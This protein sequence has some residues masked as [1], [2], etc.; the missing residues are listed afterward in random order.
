[1]K[2]VLPDASRPSSSQSA[3]RQSALTTEGK[4]IPGLSDILVGRPA[5]PSRWPSTHTDA[6]ESETGGVQV[7]SMPQ[8]PSVLAEVR[9]LRSFSSASPRT[10][11]EATSGEPGDED[12]TTITAQPELTR[13]QTWPH[14]DPEI[15]SAKPEEQKEGGGGGHS[16]P[17][18][19][20]SSS[21]AQPQ[22]QAGWGGK[23]GFEDNQEVEGEEEDNNNNNKTTIE[24]QYPAEE[25]ESVHSEEADAVFTT[26][27]EEPITAFTE[28]AEEAIFQSDDRDNHQPIESNAVTTHH[29]SPK[30]LTPFEPLPSI[31]PLFS[32]HTSTTEFAQKLSYIPPPLPEVG[33]EN[34]QQPH[35]AITIPPSPQ[36]QIQPVA[37]QTSPQESK[38]PIPVKQIPTPAHTPD[39][40]Q[41]LIST[42]SSPSSSSSENLNISIEADPDFQVS[43]RKVSNESHPRR[44]SIEV[45]VSRSDTFRRESIRA[46]PS[47]DSLLSIGSFVVE[48]SSRAPSPV[49]S[50]TRER[51]SVLFR[52][53]EVV[54]ICK[55]QQEEEEKEKEESKSKEEAVGSAYQSLFGGSSGETTTTTTVGGGRDRAISDPFTTKDTPTI[56]AR[57][58]AEYKIS[59]K[60]FEK[61]YAPEKQEEEKEQPILETPTK[62][63]PAKKKLPTIPEVRKVSTEVHPPTPTRVASSVRERKF[64]ST[65]DLIARLAGQST[66]AQELRRSR[67]FGLQRIKVPSE[68]PMDI[69]KRGERRRTISPSLRRV[70][71]QIDS[72]RTSAEHV[73]FNGEQ[74]YGTPDGSGKGKARDVTSTIEY[75]EAWGDKDGEPKSP[76]RPPSI[77]RRQS[78][79]IVDLENRLQ[80]LAAE[81]TT[82]THDKAN[83]EKSLVEAVTRGK[84]EAKALKVNLEEK[85]A[86]LEEKDSQIEELQRKISWYRTEVERL[87]QTNDAL[88]QTNDTLS[89]T[90]S[91]LSTSYK[92]SYAALTAKCDKKREAML[93]LSSE[94]S[95]LQ[96]N[97]TE[98]QSGM[99]SIIRTELSEKDAELERLRV[100]LDRAREE[101]RKLQGKVSARQTNQYIDS[102]DMAYF[103]SSCKNIFQS[104]RIF[105]KQFSS[106]STGKKCI[107][108]H[109]ITDETIRDRVEAVMLDDRGV[110]RMLKEEKRRPEVFMAIIMRM[111]WELVFTRYLF[112]LEAEERR[113]LLSLEKILTDVGAPAAV[114]QWRATT[115]TLLSQRP[116]FTPKRNAD[117]E[118][119]VSTILHQ[120]STLLPPPSQYT[121]LAHSSLT[122]IITSAVALA[123]EMRTQRAEYV[124]LRPPAPTYDENGDVNNTVPFVAARM[125]NRGTDPVT[126]EELEAEGATVKAVL[127]PTL[128]R[129]GNEFGEGYE[130]ESVVLKMQ[131]L[132]NRPLLRS[133]SRAGVRTSREL[134]GGAGGGGGGGVNRL[135]PITDASPRTTPEKTRVGGV[136]E[137]VGTTMPRISERNARVE[138]MQRRRASARR[139][140]SGSGRE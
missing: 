8:T 46:Q 50:E 4:K 123:V 27:E 48:D 86:L 28:E 120:L 126:D 110:R 90:N 116:A 63:F 128:I 87:S 127:F 3:R 53:E 69:L 30:L 20:E 108:V 136:V 88:S 70:G 47:V 82:L 18:T 114:H 133:E 109:R 102:K 14:V 77:R 49:I 36:S 79:Q 107:H 67:S 118:T 10:Q 111:V 57:E 44:D 42:S 85:Q 124:M 101:V 89:Q 22:G 21:Q 6:G 93:K 58:K 140:G 35:I 78:M 2:D 115:L 39:P 41:P 13:S 26:F 97:F 105:C 138:R 83:V 135:T 84:D 61:P 31:E 106:F 95:D 119:V 1:M 9:S 129:R 23:E 51:D 92:F 5:V 43:V 113:K 74:R 112:G 34:T 80:A 131:V 45:S 139:S 32:Q 12:V 72:P 40:E 64:I 66:P 94:H 117:I 38:I 71:S 29:S 55:Q 15:D 99:E 81:N 52:E 25:K 33:E 24:H 62:P 37:K 96:R 65:E 132:V 104:V 16:R 103:N 122:T 54:G 91:T 56:A 76:T 98:M 125:A 11:E 134:A 121:R 60:P 137:A 75:F 68:D 7:P 130:V 17:S 100:E 59:T 73:I 19:A